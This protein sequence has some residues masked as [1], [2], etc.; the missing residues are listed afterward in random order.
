MKNENQD[1]VGDKCVK[2]GDGCLTFNNSAKLKA[3]KSYY[4]RLLNV[5]IMQNSNSPPD[6]EP[7]IGPPLY[8]TEEMISKAIAKMK[9]GKAARPSGTVIEIIRSAG[10]EIIKSITNLTNRIIKEGRI[11]SGLNLS[12][13]VSLYKSKGDAL[14]RDNNRGLKMLNQIMKIIGRVLDSVI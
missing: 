11:P 14:S 4:E 7:Q 13:I 9:T 12:Y 8:I 5:E 10:K 2:N 6:L 1:T 3:W